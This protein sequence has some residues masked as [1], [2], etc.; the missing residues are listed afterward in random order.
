MFAGSDEGA[1]RS[2]MFYTFMGTCKLNN[3]NPMEWLTEILNRIEDHKLNKLYEL[4]PQNLK[5]P[6]K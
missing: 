4:F 6:E 1:K 5:L 2:A 3:V